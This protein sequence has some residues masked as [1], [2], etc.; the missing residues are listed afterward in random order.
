M[1]NKTHGICK[2]TPRKQRMCYTFD[3]ILDVSQN[4]GVS[5]EIM[6]I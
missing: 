5:L 1:F 6:S 2:L 3:I 4:S